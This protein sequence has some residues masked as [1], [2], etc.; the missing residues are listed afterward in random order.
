MTS[1]VAK[2]PLFALSCLT[3]LAHHSLLKDAMFYQIL[4]TFPDTFVRTGCWQL[5]DQG[6]LDFTFTQWSLN[7]FKE[8]E[9]AGFFYDNSSSKL[10]L[11][12]STCPFSGSK[13]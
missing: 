4:F 13:P 1:C 2:R 6:P 7:L 12:T 8:K 11:L 9:C 3:L 10:P 5:A